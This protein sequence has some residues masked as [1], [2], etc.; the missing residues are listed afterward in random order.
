MI[1]QLTCG[2][3]AAEYIDLERFRGLPR[4]SGAA[5]VGVSRGIGVASTLSHPQNLR[6]RALLACS[7]GYRQSPCAAFSSMR[8]QLIAAAVLLG[9]AAPSGVQ[10]VT[11][12]QACQTFASKLS[13]AQKAGDKQKAQEIYAKGNQRI[14]KKFNGATCPN[15]KVPTP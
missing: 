3:S 9:L 7:E 6:G 4:G 5:P 15:V 13:D 1:A 14:A 10:A 12:D 2:A 11:L 8:P